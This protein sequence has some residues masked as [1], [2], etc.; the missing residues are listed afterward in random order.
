MIGLR[1]KLTKNLSVSWID[2]DKL[3]KLVCPHLRHL[4]IQGDNYCRSGIWVA[5]EKDPC[6]TC[7]HAGCHNRGL[8]HRNKNQ[9]VILKK[10]KNEKI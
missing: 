2:W 8:P 7:Q 10:R 9:L 5:L 1:K 3:D 6:P 4:K